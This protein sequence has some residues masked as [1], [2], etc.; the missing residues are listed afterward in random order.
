MRASRRSRRVG[1]TLIELLV[2]LAILAVLIGLLLPAVQKVRESAA[3]MSCG[4]NLK[5]LALAC[6]AYHDA[7]GALP[8]NTQGYDLGAWSW[9]AQSQQRSW[10]WL[11][12]ILPHVEQDNLYRRGNIPNATFAEAEALGVLAT[13][14]QAFFCPSDTASAEKTRTDREN[15]EG[16]A[17][18][19][20]NYKG[21][22]GSNWCWGDWVNP[23]PT[24]NCDGLMAGDG[25]FY[26][27]DWK[28][29][30]KLA[31]ITNGTSNTF[32]VGE[33]LPSKNRHCSW[34]YSNNS[35]GTCGIGPNSKRSNGTEYDISD[36]GNVYSFRS[37]HAN[38][39][40]FANADGSVRLVHNSIPLPV[41]RALATIQGGEPV[42]QDD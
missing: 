39:L 25:V 37:R 4:N 34:P 16:P 14:V 29:P 6:H 12:R 26:R 11:A 42:T 33:D 8:T 36:W 21:V 15:I 9:A 5:Q 41:Y 40:Q 20:T 1:F 30:R 24:G 35:V 22:S 28:R 7:Q 18:A 2:V 38:G 13:P 27:D 19:L 17:I 32:L 31:D 3:R 10:S 23:G